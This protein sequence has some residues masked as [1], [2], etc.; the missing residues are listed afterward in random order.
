MHRSVGGI[1]GGGPGPHGQGRRGRGDEVVR[2]ADF[3]EQPDVSAV[4]ADLVDGLG[5]T[6]ITKLGGSV[7]GEHEERH[8]RLIRLDDCREVVR[9]CGSR[10]ADESGRD[11]ALFGDSESEE[12]GRSLVVYHVARDAILRSEGCSEGSAA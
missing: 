2:H 1:E 12:A 9:R 4:D 3:M 10:R 7:G 5:G 8:A 11:P 6:D